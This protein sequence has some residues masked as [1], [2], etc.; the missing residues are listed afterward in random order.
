MRDFTRLK[1]L[2]TPVWNES[3][4]LNTFLSCHSPI[5]DFI[6][7]ADQMSSDGSREIAMSYKNVILIDNTKTDFN[8][9]HMR[10]IMLDEARIRFGDGNLL[11]ALDADEL[12]FPQVLAEKSLQE[13]CNRNPG[14][15]FKLARYNLRPDLES[16]WIVDGGICGFI[17]DGS[18]FPIDG[19]IHAPRIPN[20]GRHLTLSFPLEV[21]QLH[22]QFIDWERMELKHM[23]YRRWEMMNLRTSPLVLWRKYNHMNSIPSRHLVVIE[24]PVNLKTKLAEAASQ[25]SK[26]EWI[27]RIERLGRE[28]PKKSM[29]RL[30][31]LE[32]DSGELASAFDKFVKLYQKY[33]GGRS[34]PTHQRYTFRFFMLVDRLI[35]WLLLR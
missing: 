10:Q 20:P 1:I 5:F 4:I 29:E 18:N 27:Q 24:L 33:T 6:V 25:P 12:L 30:L 35:D 23:W 15:R 13:A 19:L 8:E 3:W 16:A 22:L 7:I 32:S 21:H 28:I 34:S 11:V 9:P 26:G 31:L 2:M 14:T 17:D